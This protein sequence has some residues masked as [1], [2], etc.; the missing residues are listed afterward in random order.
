MSNG[1]PAGGLFTGAETL[2]V[3]SLSHSFPL[4]CC[5][6]SF[7]FFVRLNPSDISL[8]DSSLHMIPATINLVL[9]LILLITPSLSL[10]PLLPFCF[11]LCLKPIFTV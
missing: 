9:I 6:S 11:F 10:P 2:K 3:L 8:A 7:I 5:R 1:I 4:N